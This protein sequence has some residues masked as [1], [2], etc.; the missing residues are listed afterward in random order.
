MSAKYPYLDISIRVYD[1]DHN[2]SVVG[3]GGDIDLPPMENLGQYF[4]SLG[5]GY[6]MWADDTYRYF[7]YFMMGPDGQ[8]PTMTV[9]VGMPRA[10]LMP[11]RSLTSLLGAVRSRVREG[12]TVTE[13]LLDRLAGE[14]G[15]PEHPLMAPDDTDVNAATKL[16]GCRTYNS[17]AELANIFG[18]PRQKS[19]ADYGAIVVVPST[20]L[21]ADEPENQMPAITAPI[22]KALMVVTPE[23]VTVS[24]D[25][26]EFSDHLTVVYNCD[27]FDPVSVMFEVGTTNR[28]VRINGPALVVN[29]ALHAGII[30]HKRIP[31][32]VTSGGGLPI[33]TYT[34]LINGRTA[35]RT[36]EGFEISNTDFVAPDGSPMK[37][38]ITVSSTNFSAY[39]REFTPEELS[40]AAPLEVVLEP[41]SR[42]IVLRL[43]FGGG[44]IVEESLN[45]EKNT[46]EYCQLRAGRFHGFRAHRLMGATPETYNVD[47]R[48]SYEAPQPQPQAAKF[49]PE[50]EQPAQEQSEANEAQSGHRGPVAPVIEKAPT[51]IWKEESHERRAPE[52]ANET[53]PAEETDENAMPREPRKPINYG[54]I[55][56]V[57]V[58]VGLAIIIIWYLA[59][60]F[61]GSDQP[62]DQADSLQTEQTATNGATD[63]SAA[64]AAQAPASTLTAEETAD[65]EYLNDHSKWRREELKSETGRKL[66]DD[67]AAGDVDA[68]AS[69]DYFSVKDR[70]ANREANKLV[71]M[72]WKGKGS[73]MEKSQKNIMTKGLAKGVADIHALYESVARKQ[74][75]E[76]K[77]TEPRPQK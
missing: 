10:V 23:D 26:V 38:K 70:C 53:R 20:V 3:T 21:T 47:V 49:T 75:S 25:R 37:A 12:E 64:T 2:Y 4:M 14:S 13:A 33:D 36:E 22:D 39:S 52:F 57:A 34:I 32:T 27:G 55:A 50:A 42:D 65:I 76:V 71:D 56:I 30:F 17:S 19:Y 41:E 7:G 59:S 16:F 15:F 60:V 11:G 8:K 35:N 1:A 40:Q 48:P 44:R 68:I 73:S 63:G 54:K 43:D 74:P 66:F 61:S 69:S 72:L 9:T 67:M 58:T 51:A 77:N 62:T 24:A 6:L 18:F 5:D 45:I 46:P 29:S 31:Y 28:Y